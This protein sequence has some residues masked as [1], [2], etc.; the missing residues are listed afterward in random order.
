MKKLLKKATL[1]VVSTIAF[2]LNSFAQT[3]PDTSKT[4]ISTKTL[5]LTPNQKALFKANKEKREAARKQFKATLTAEQK[6]IMADKSLTKD[7]KRNKLAATLSPEQN[8]MRENNKTMA[9]E[10][11]NELLKTLTPEQKKAFKSKNQDWKA[12]RKANKADAEVLKEY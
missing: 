10:N 5:N 4:D 6:L 3:S 12:K 7:E 1:V 11:R 9:K 8:Q 2:S